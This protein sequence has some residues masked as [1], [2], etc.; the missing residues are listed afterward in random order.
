MRLEPNVWGPQYW[1]V[2][3][4]IALTYSTRP[5]ETIKKKYYDFIHNIPLFLPCEEMGNEFSKI[6][7]KYPVTPYLDSRDSL[8]KW[9]HF[10]HN[11]INKS[12]GKEEIELGDALSSYYEN[13]KPKIKVDIETKKRREKIIFI[14]MILILIV[15]N[16]YLFNK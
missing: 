11:K 4:T 8:I 7:D 10:I 5:N 13:Y 12:L 6:L 3:H 9:V 14:S 1:F 16:I 2:L 15:I